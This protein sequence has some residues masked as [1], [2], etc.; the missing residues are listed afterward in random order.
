MGEHSATGWWY[1]YIVVFLL[2]TPIP[3]LILLILLAIYFKRVK[4]NYIYGENIGIFFIVLFSI[5]SIFSKLQLSVRYLLPIYPLLFI[6]I[7]KLVNVKI[8]K[9]KI[10]N[11]VLISLSFWYLLNSISVYPDYIPFFNGFAGGPDNG[12][13][14]LRDANVDFGQDLPSLEKYMRLNNVRYV[15]LA[16][17]GTADPQYYGIRYDKI[18]DHEKISPEKYLYAISAN[19][20]D[21]IEWVNDIEPTAK[22]G[23]SIFIY[24]LRNKEQQDTRR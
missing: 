7:S 24:D 16:Y 22:A 5:A 14:Y 8:N 12:W 4:P 19:S 10:L 17:Y 15:K 20:I 1:Y 23:Y 21:G 11:I 3:I 13:A 9:Q 2:K 18:S 6:Y